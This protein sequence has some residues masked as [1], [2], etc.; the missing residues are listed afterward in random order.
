MQAKNSTAKQKAARRAGP[1]FT[2][3]G[4]RAQIVAAAIEVIAEAGY[5]RASFAKIAERAGLSS[6]GMISYHFDGRD[7]L[8]REVVTDVM[9]LAEGYLRPRI[10]AHESYAARLRAS[11]EGNLDLC[12]E[13]PNHLA[14]IVEILANLRGGDPGMVAFL[15][16]TEANLAVQVEQLRKA[17]RT[18]EFRDFD[19]WVMMRAIRAAID[20]VVRRATHDPGLDVRA[21][22][23]ELADLFDRATRST[24]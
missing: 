22:G 6:T 10:E 23:R 14:A 12:A 16:T 2:E 9:R 8:M 3:T 20:D 11:I 13:Y 24:S 21:A 19:P 7:D 1:S 18:G 5:H 15:D 4:R 17:Q